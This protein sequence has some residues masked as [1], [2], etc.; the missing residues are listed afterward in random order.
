[1]TFY[2]MR[3]NELKVFNEERDKGQII[4]NSTAEAGEAL[5]SKIN[6]DFREIVRSELKNLRSR[7][8]KLGDRANAAFKK[9]E[10]DM[11]HRSSFE[12]KY[13]QVSFSKSK[14]FSTIIVI[15]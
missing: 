3:L 8:D 14:Y 11:M 7:L 1:M 12:D 5:Y 15:C 4:F 6:P 9:I 13:S 2:Q 10:N